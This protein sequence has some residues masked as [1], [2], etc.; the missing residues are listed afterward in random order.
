[1]TNKKKVNPDEVYFRMR[2]MEYKS[3]M[4]KH[5]LFAKRIEELDNE[6]T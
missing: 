3:N 4:K 6:M 2:E 1:M 5:K